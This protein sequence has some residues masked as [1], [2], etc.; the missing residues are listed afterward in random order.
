VQSCL[1]LCAVEDAARSTGSQSCWAR[2]QSGESLAATSPS[3]SSSAGTKMLSPSKVSLRQ[4]QLP[5]AVLAR[6]KDRGWTQTDLGSG[7]WVEQGRRLAALCSDSAAPA[8]AGCRALQERLQ[9]LKLLE[10]QSLPQGLEALRAAL[11]WKCSTLEHAYACLDVGNRRNCGGISL[12]DF[13]GAMALLGLDAP[14]LCGGREAAA[15]AA[16]DGDRD[17]RMSL[18]DLLGSS[19]PAPSW[20]STRSSG[21]GAKVEDTDGTAVWVLVVKFAALSSWFA[22]PPLLRQRLRS[23][24]KAQDGALLP[25]TDRPETPAA[26]ARTVVTALAE[27][28]AGIASHGAV[29]RQQVTDPVRQCW[30]PS[31]HDLEALEEELK[32]EHFEKNSSVRQHGEQALSKSDFFRLLKD[33][34]PSGIGDD[35]EPQSLT[36][37]QLAHIFDE[38]L[39]RQMEGMAQSGIAIS[40]GLT[41]KSF[42]FALLKASIVMGLHFRGLVNDAIDAQQI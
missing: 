11:K 18:P 27:G 7:V 42:R 21:S 16:I 36:R 28:A 38:V 31:E 37:A 8:A 26:G 9:L 1:R 12:L 23:L 20:C 22:I 14:S 5:N 39:A 15:F 41:F 6:I 19:A 2:L 17:G 29:A 3:A 40:K 25:H 13:S 10:Q 30:A 24:P 34:P 32:E 33:I 4:R 35:P